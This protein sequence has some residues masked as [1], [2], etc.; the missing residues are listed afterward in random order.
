MMKLLHLY[1][2]RELVMQLLHNWDYDPSRKDLLDQYRISSNA[3]YPIYCDDS[4]C[5]LRFAP[6]SEKS[7]TSVASEIDFVAYLRSHG[8]GAPE[9]LP[10]K[11]GQN[12]LLCN[13][14]WGDY[15]VAVFR[16]VPGKR[17]DMIELNADI[18]EKYGRNL[19]R[20]HLLSRDYH[21]SGA[22]RKS[23]HDLLDSAEA[24]LIKYHAPDSAL[25]ELNIL[26]VAFLELSEDSDQYG[27]IHYD[28]ELDNVF[29]DAVSDAISTIDFDDSHYHWYGMDLERALANLEEEL[30]EEKLP[31]AKASFLDGYT[32]LIKLTP[33]CHSR[34][35]LF[36]RYAGFVQYVRC[37]RASYDFDENEPEWMLN[38]RKHLTSLMHKNEADFGKVLRYGS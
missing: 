25:T 9:L 18:L 24:C 38:L 1:D 8:L 32:S 3:I 31:A 28:Y 15:S 21:P 33:E 27:L 26:R 5:F 6:I 22:R 37:L 36:K 30:E 23:W 35:P 14:P 12:L 17:M 4:I 29:Y 2:N 34:F 19:A 7:F 16:R 20:L 13:T 10:A 11:N